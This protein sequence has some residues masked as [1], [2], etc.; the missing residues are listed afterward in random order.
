MYI[1]FSGYI[2]ILDILIFVYIF[3]G[4]KYI[5]FGYN[6]LWY[7]LGISYTKKSTKSYI[8]FWIYPKKIYKNWIFMKNS[9]IYPKKDILVIT[10]KRNFAPIYFGYIPFR[11]IFVVISMVITFFL[12]ITPD[13]FTKYSLYPTIILDIFF[14]NSF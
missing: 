13:I 3:F 5:F 14:K 10:K 9:W 1:F 6:C 7:I 2:N 4:S 11:Y 8:F 12:V